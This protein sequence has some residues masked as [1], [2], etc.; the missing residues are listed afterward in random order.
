M[1]ARHRAVISCLFERVSATLPEWLSSLS[2]I[3]NRT[4][5][6]DT[7]ITRA[8]DS[9]VHVVVAGSSQFRSSLETVDSALETAVT[10]L[11]DWTDNDDSKVEGIVEELERAFLIFAD[12]DID[13]APRSGASI[14]GD[15]QRDLAFLSVSRSH[16]SEPGA[17]DPFLPHHNHLREASM[18]KKISITVAAAALFAGPLLT[19]VNAQAAQSSHDT[20]TYAPTPTMTAVQPLACNGTTGSE[21]CGPGWI[22]NGSRC[23]RC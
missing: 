14:T 4:L 5:V 13:L 18:R 8:N 15:I 21:G 23:V 16:E 19:G 20:T 17:Y 2:N 3:P 10:T 6:F 12:H 1:W 11:Q 9:P 7:S 22:W